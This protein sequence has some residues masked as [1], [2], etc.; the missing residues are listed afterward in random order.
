M[1]YLMQ[2]P[3]GRSFTVTRLKYFN[4]AVGTLS[5]QWPSQITCEMEDLLCNK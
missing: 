2:T 4:R 3:G 1:V 5:N